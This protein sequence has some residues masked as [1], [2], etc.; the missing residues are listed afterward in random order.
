MESVWRR[1]IILLT[2]LTCLTVSDAGADSGVGA[3]TAAYALSVGESVFISPSASLKLDRIDD[4]RCKIGAA[5]IWAGY[6]SYSF[7]LNSKAGSST[8]TLSDS[9]PGGTRS[10]SLQKMT[11]ALLSIDPASPPAVDAQTPAYRVTIQISNCLLKK[12]R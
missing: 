4:S 9:M 7:T 12:R 8:F 2:L 3:G 1:S 6:I 5:C 10:V 11:F